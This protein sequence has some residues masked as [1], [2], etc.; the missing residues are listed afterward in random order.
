MIKL[1]Q[2]S[3]SQI[4]RQQQQRQ[5]PTSTSTNKTTVK[6]SC[7]ST[8]TEA[9][10]KSQVEILDEAFTPA[11]VGP[12]GGQRAFS[13]LQ[14]YRSMVLIL[15]QRLVVWYKFS[16]PVFHSIHHT[17]GQTKS[18]NLF[19]DTQTPQRWKILDGLLVSQARSKE[20]RNAGRFNTALVAALQLASGD[21]MVGDNLL[22]SW[23]PASEVMGDSL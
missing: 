15:G 2:H 20:L 1:Q 21:R 10:P 14:L 7:E 8:W 3:W 11:V 18:C 17:T 5:Q 9:K 19:G 6:S 13:I 16:W 4:K 23:S 22:V 12:K